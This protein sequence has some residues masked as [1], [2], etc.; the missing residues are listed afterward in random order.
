MILPKVI[1]I[2]TDLISD[3]NNLNK[4][5]HFFFVLINLFIYLFLTALGLRC[6]AWAFL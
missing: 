1:M 6:C 4:E 3:L 5:T 2:L